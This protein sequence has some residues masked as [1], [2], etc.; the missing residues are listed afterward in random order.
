MENAELELLYFVVYEN[1][2]KSEFQIIPAFW[3]E[4][5][6]QREVGD[7]GFAKLHYIIIGFNYHI[8]LLKHLLVGDKV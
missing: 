6:H 7:G 5:M 1:E 8:T 3:R 2:T 4:I